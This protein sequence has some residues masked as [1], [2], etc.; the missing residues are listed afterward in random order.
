M[1]RAAA[2][3]IAVAVYAS[4]ALAGCT[5]GDAERVGGERAADIRVLTMLDPIGNRQELTHFVDEVSRLS[6]GALEIRF[7]S[8]GHDGAD[9]ETATIRDVQDGRA[10]L[11]F[12]G[13]RA[14]DEFGARSLRALGAPFLVDSYPLQEAVLTSGLVDSM[15]DE[16][17][18]M[19]L[20]GIGI[21]PGP[22]RRALGV[23][24]TLASP[25]DFR[26]LTIGTQ[27]SHVADA[28]LRALGARPQ[29]LPAHVTRLAGLDGI[30]L[31]VA[32]IEA[33]RLDADGSRLMTNVNLWPRPLVV[34]AGAR[35][36]Q[37]LS[38]DQRQILRDA[39]A[40]A[41]S[42]KI[43]AERDLEAETGTNLC[44]KDRATFDSATPEQLQALR[45]AVEPVYGE[46]ERDPGTR[47]A[48][49]AIEQL[50]QQL[51]EPPTQIT[52]CQP[53]SD[54]ST[55]GAATEIDGVWTM[56]TDRQAA[57][58]ENLDENWGHWIYVFDRGRFAITQENETSC[59]W[60]YGTYAV[61]GNRMSWT[62]EDGGGITP[63][64][65]VNR[66]GEYFVFDFSAYRDTLTVTPVDGEISPINFRAEP[67]RQLSDTASREHF[68]ER[69]PPPAAA[70][71][72]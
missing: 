16:L 31:A 41:V 11:A 23:A 5:V 25:G 58:P 60:G 47:A 50:K 35:A 57:A 39:A 55:S 28:T 30:E 9:Y 52:N 20:V 17:Q 34:F 2:L 8:A 54:A 48:I 63:N 29:R 37:G 45:G 36:Y 14:W 62:F 7:V 68:S 32:A 1:T 66:P 72:G 15:L 44:R 46:L 26:G 49:E 21:L 33:G 69:C 24:N 56:D 13:S 42:E 18:P 3:R 19:G 71:H 61:D 38:D 65:A 6:D 67:W 64:N 12:A 27:Q 70:L 40:N 53:A 10:D 51:A 59:T 4:V 43:T 22:I